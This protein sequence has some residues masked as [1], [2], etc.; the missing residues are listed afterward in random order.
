VENGLKE[1][2]VLFDIIS[3]KLRIDRDATT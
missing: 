2:T 1:S 3:L